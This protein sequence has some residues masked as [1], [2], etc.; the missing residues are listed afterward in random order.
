MTQPL[1]STHTA[2]KPI[3]RSLCI[4]CFLATLLYFLPS[5]CR[6][7]T[8][9]FSIARIT[10]YL[11]K[12]LS[13]KTPQVMQEEAAEL[14]HAFS[15]PYRYLGH[16]GQCFAF[17]SHDDRYVIKFL[18]TR[19]HAFGHPSLFSLPCFPEKIR[20]RKMQ[21]ALFKLHRDFNS[22]L[23]ASTD[24]KEETGIFYVHLDKTSD[25]KKKVRI[26][27]K[28]GIAHTLDLDHFSFIVQR[29]AE[30]ACSYLS[31]LI[32]K[33]EIEKAKSAICSLLALIQK[34]C[35][36]GYYDE[37]AKIVRDNIGFIAQRPLFIDVGRFVKDP[38]KQNE[39]IYK[40][41]M[42]DLSLQLERWIRD[43]YPYLI[44]EFRE[45]LI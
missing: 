44:Q 38:A 34:R 21:K 11:P 19:F 32:E 39:Q 2:K 15:Q 16:G 20:E 42:R 41:D 33:N 7:Q 23:F 13:W 8:D 24:L 36:K 26:T 28:L 22:Y 4:Y 6:M 10:S 30:P 3:A 18:K 45:I 5:F 35:Q 17:L 43:N 31:K 40:Q 29:R 12:G 9:G 25:L 1:L 14:S 27:D 37:D